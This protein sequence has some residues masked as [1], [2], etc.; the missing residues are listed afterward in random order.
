[1]GVLDVLARARGPQGS[2][3]A[4]PGRS[5]VTGIVG[6]GPCIRGSLRLDGRASSRGTS[7]G[8]PHPEKAVVGQALGGMMPVELAVQ[9]HVFHFVDLDFALWR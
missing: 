3:A 5:W 8:G 6:E 4:R 2:L 9:D 7:V 1:M